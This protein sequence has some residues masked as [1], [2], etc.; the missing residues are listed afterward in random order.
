MLLPSPRL[1]TM[2]I[3]RENKK[4]RGTPVLKEIRLSVRLMVIK[5]I[6]QRIE[7]H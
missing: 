6:L 3:D 7:G 1:A 4:A 5:W 2:Q